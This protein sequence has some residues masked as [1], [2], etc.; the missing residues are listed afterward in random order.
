MTTSVGITTLRSRQRPS[1]AVYVE[2]RLGTGTRTM[3]R[4]WVLRSFGAPSF[5]EFWR[6]WNPVYGYVLTYFVYRP[7]RTFAPRP[8]AVWLTFVACGFFLHDLIGWLLRRE[9][10]VPEMTILFA[11]FGGAVVLTNAV[12][13]DLSRQP[14]LL[15]IAVNCSFVV[16]AWGVMRLVTPA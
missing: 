3:L 12:H 15:R 2:R 10:R 8:V 14:L 5:G 4:N 1:L 13:L 16:I 11:F 6:Y 7:L 9:V